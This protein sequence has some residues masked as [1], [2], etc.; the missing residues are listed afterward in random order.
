MRGVEDKLNQVEPQLNDLAVIP[1]LGIF[2][3]ATKAAIG[4]IQIIAGIAVSIF[5]I[6]TACCQHDTSNLSLSGSIILHGFGNIFGGVV[7]AIP[8][9]GTIIVLIRWH[10]KPHEKTQFFSY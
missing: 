7:L 9:I 3:G 5:L 4:I 2:S 1:G 8:L 10:V 6:A